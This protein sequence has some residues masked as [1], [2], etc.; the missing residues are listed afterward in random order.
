VRRLVDAAADLALDL[1]G[2]NTGAAS[3]HAGQRAKWV[4]SASKFVPASVQK[5][6]WL[7]D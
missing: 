2:E 1:D 6:E 7:A 5:A 4:E 3:D